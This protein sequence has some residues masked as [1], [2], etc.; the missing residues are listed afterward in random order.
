MN[1]RIDPGYTY[2]Q[3]VS[4]GGK[5]MMA[6]L[7]PESIMVTLSR[8]TNDPV[9]SAKAKKWIFITLVALLAITSINVAAAFQAI[10][11]LPL[12]ITNLT[13]MVTLGLTLFMATKKL[14]RDR[15]ILLIMTCALAMTV[16][17]TII[18]CGFRSPL[19]AGYA[20]NYEIGILLLLCSSPWYVLMA[21]YRER[22]SIPIV[23]HQPNQPQSV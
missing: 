21:A 6:Y 12:C 11:N 13:L 2:S 15:D 10:D 17:L 20:H 16:A 5:S 3:A 7:I 18:G 4:I 9:E 8:K 14:A 19:D 22:A 23:S 1:A